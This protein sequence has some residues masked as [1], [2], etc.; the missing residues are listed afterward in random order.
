MFCVVQDIYRHAPNNSLRRRHLPGRDL[1]RVDRRHLHPVRAAR[2]R[3]RRRRRKPRRAGR[4]LPPPDM[5]MAIDKGKSLGEEARPRCRQDL[6]LPEDDQDRQRPE[7]LRSGG[8][9]PRHRRAPARAPTPTSPACSRCEERDGIGLYDQIR[10]LRGIQWPAPTLRDRQGRA[11]RRAATWA[12]RAGPGKPYGEFRHPDG[13]A[14][15]KL[16]EQDYG[17]NNAARSRTYG[18]GRSRR[19][20]LIRRAKG[21]GSTR[22]RTFWSAPAT[23]RWPPELPDL[24]F[25]DDSSQVARGRQEGG[26]VSLLARP[27]HRLRA[28]PHRQDDPRRDHAASWCPSSTSRCNETDAERYGLEDG[29]TVRLVTRR[30]SYEARVSDRHDVD[31]PPGAQRGARATCSARGTSRWPTA[32]TRKNNRWLVNAVSHRAWDPVAARRTTRSSPRASSASRE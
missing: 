26:Q 12:R 15:F 19:T 32:P 27:G 11:A 29:E 16:C 28:L 25:Y 30:A 21:P 24:D 9:L 5:D 31:G 6:S 1:G 22:T 7:A 10:D 4:D 3:L 14:H 13:K 20:A 2:L 18:Q 23:T 8:R 17:V